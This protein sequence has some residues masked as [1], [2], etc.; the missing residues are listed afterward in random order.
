MSPKTRE[1]AGE[2]NPIPRDPM[3]PKMMKMYSSALYFIIL[4]MEGFKIILSSSS[5]AIACY[6]NVEQLMNDTLLTPAIS[7]TSAL[8]HS[9]TIHSPNFSPS[10]C[11]WIG[12]K[13]HVPTVPH[14]ERSHPRK[15]HCWWTMIFRILTWDELS[16]CPR[17][18]CYSFLQRWRLPSKSRPLDW[19]QMDNELKLHTTCKNIQPHL[20]SDQCV[21]DSFPGH[22]F[23]MT[24]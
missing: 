13:L 9:I 11:C 4:V 22:E 5:S 10:S 21:I 20:S 12:R 19:P 17:E 3:Q 7:S 6:A 16:L 24:A 2:L 23:V 15:C 1:N 14:L 18:R 8:L